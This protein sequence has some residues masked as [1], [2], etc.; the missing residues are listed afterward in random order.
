[1]TERERLLAAL[2]HKEPDRVPIDLGGTKQTSICKNAYIDFMKYLNIDLDEDTIEILNIVQ[3]LP[4]L[5]K[6]LIER[7]SACALPVYPNPPSSWILDMKAEGEYITYLD[8][9]GAK[10]YSNKGGYYFDYREFPMKDSTWEAFNE[11]KWPDPSDP[12]R[13]KGL[14]E[15]A[16]NLYEN[17]DYALVGF[18]ASIFGGGVFEHPAMFHGMVEFLTLC[19]AEPE[20]AD[21]MMEKVCELYLES[22]SRF[23]DEVGPYLQVFAFNDDISTQEGPMVSPQFYK[24]YIKPKHRRIC[25]LIKSKTNAKIFF[26]SCG[27]CYEFIGDF[28]DTGFDILNPIQTTAK[29]MGDLVKLKKEFGN[30][31]VFWGGLDTQ[32]V[33]SFGSPGDVADEVKKVMDGLAAGG[34]YVF[35]AVHNIQPFVPPENIE[36]MYKAAKEYGEY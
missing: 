1:M 7:V 3:Q 4:V 35:A 14:K 9:W 32:K 33:L 21:A 29:G 26:H 25:D 24:K 11:M 15:K 19:A 23:L 17:T 27:A 28:I 18:L 10:L 13:V 12:Q 6:Q 5:D 8:E 30:D 16:K 34:G 22:I 36:M 2:N 31:I 20:L